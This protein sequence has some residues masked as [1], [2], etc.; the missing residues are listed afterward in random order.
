[1][2]TVWRKVWRDLYARLDC[3]AQRMGRVELSDGRWPT[4]RTLAVERMTSRHLD[5]PLGATIL[6]QVGRRERG[7]PV[8][9]IVRDSFA[10]PPQFG[11]TPIFFTTPK[12][13]TW[14]TADDVNRLDVRL[15]SYSSVED[16]QEVIDELA[17][18]IERIGMSVQV[19]GRWLRDPSE[20]WFQDSVD[21]VY[22]ILV[23]LGGLAMALSA[24]LIVNTMNAIVSQQVWQVG[25]M[26]V[27]GATFGRVVSLYLRIALIYS[28]LALLLAVPL[29][30]IGAH[31]LARWILNIVN[32]AVGSL[33]VVPLAAGVQIAVG[34]MV[35]LLAAAV[36]V[37][38]G[39]R[40]T[41]HKAISTYGL[42]S[43]FGQ[44]LLDRL[45]GMLWPAI[46][47]LLSALS[48]L[49]PALQATR[50]SVREALAYE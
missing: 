26:K 47:V 34:L 5:I 31:L 43:G 49:V 33:R 2:N 44:G 25:V 22:A 7:L 23:V 21:T 50:V 6:V 27:V 38:G 45:V 17:E 30:A 39:A 14:L 18:R 41:A 19:W 35:P 9:G 42:G 48:S 11:A 10:D 28:G 29:G 40:I 37:I 46:A 20:H 15:T 12:T 16:A 13:A 24:F 32:I 4:A 8:V 1:M 3:E 36:P